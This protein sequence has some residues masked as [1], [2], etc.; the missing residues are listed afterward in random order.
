MSSTS[1]GQKKTETRTDSSVREQGLTQ[2]VERSCLCSSLLIPCITI[3]Y[4]VP[5]CT[6]QLTPKFGLPGGASSCQRGERT[7]AK[8]PTKEQ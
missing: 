4:F 1:E 8:N 5:H 2:T 3:V 6:G 7:Q